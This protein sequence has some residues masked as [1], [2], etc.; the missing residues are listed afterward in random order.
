MR[1]FAS[2]FGLEDA[3]QIPEIQALFPAASLDE[4]AF[5]L[6]HAG[7][8]HE[9]V[10]NVPNIEVAEA[11]FNPFI[12]P[13][14]EVEDDPARGMDDYIFSWYLD[15]EGTYE[16]VAIGEEQAL[17][18]TGMRLARTNIVIVIASIKMVT[19]YFSLG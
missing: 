5:P 2:L 10:I 14:I 16:E 6:P 3:L 18:M 15:D 4:T 7:I 9:A 1:T 12:S 11:S 17:S 13:G 19:I 8:M